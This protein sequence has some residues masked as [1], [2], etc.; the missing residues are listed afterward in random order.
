MKKRFFLIM[1][2]AVILE[3][4]VLDYFKIFGVKPD[5]ILLSVIAPSLYYL[6]TKWC[7]FFAILAGILKDVLGI[8]SFG[9]NTFLFPL[10]VILILKVSKKISLDINFIRIAI[11]L[12]VTILNN[13]AAGLILLSWGRFI[14]LLS[15]LR[16]LLVQTVYTTAVSY[17]LFKFLK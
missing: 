8:N 6:E 3:A 15:F 5:L 14:P 2:I 17:P 16:I 12:A 10:W 7:V 13:L 11:V 9:I 4:A 1:I